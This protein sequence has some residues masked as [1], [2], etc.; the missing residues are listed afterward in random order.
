MDKT[1]LIRIIL[2]RTGYNLETNSGNMHEREYGIGFYDGYKLA[3]ETMLLCI[4]MNDPNRTKL[5]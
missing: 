3:M 5:K 4:D 2:E 1:E